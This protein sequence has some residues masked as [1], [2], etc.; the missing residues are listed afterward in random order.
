MHQSFVVALMAAAAATGA[1]TSGITTEEVAR[2]LTA[3]SAAKD[4]RPIELKNGRAACYA[5][6]PTLRVRLAAFAAK[7]EY[8]AL[9]AASVTEEMLAPTA[10]IVCSPIRFLKGGGDIIGV[11]TVVI[12]PKG[13]PAIQPT[14]SEPLPERYQNAYGSTFDR[15]GMLAVFPLEAFKVGSELRVVYSDKVAYSNFAKPSDD[16]GIEIKAIASK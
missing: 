3:G 4:V 13:G 5:T 1:A 16:V 12:L 9:D 15:D 6:T 8:R 14:H 10:E 2:E 11:R 7:K